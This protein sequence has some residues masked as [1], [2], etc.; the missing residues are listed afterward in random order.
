MEDD[1]ELKSEQ[2]SASEKMQARGEK[3]HSVH[4]PVLSGVYQ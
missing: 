2:P 1:T 4:L 3:Q